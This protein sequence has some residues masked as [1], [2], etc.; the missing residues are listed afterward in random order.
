MEKYRCGSDNLSTTSGNILVSA[1]D[2]CGSSASQSLSI[3]VSNPS[4]LLSTT[5][6]SCTD[7]CDA[8]IS[9]VASGGMPGYSYMPFP[10][11]NLCAGN[12]T[13]TVT[14]NLGC[15]G[16]GTTTISNPAPVSILI[17]ASDTILCLG[18]ASNVSL[19]GADTY[20]W[21][22]FSSSSTFSFSPVISDYWVAV[23]T[24]T[25]TGCTATD[26]VYFTVNPSPVVNFVYPGSDTVCITDGIQIL[27]GGSPSGGT[28]TGTGVSGTS[29]DPNV[30]GIGNHSV[31]YT[32][33]DVNG[34]SSSDVSTIEVIGCSGIEQGAEVSFIV[35]PNP[36]TNQL[37]FEGVK[38][39]IEAKL[40]SVWGESL[41]IWKVNE[42]NPVISTF[43][44]VPGV[45]FLG[46][47][48]ATGIKM[49]RII[50]QNQ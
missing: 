20:T 6:P 18:D 40:Y 1:N 16:T 2:A 36:F 44:L 26:S 15:I 29:F 47:R 41:Y 17:F 11:S 22:G 33:T 27:S 28:Y 19:N 45:Y 31:T 3:F 43:H 32:F 34:C 39:T 5:S 14:D 8:S 25:A 42:T 48:T 24:V 49:Q 10:L 38:G 46:I 12:Y 9:P 23:G 21:G 50:K 30:A 4:L 35:Y 37:N 13:V 7:S